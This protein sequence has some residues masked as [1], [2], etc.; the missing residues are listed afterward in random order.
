MNKK[1]EVL[2]I[3]S[4][5]MS[6]TQIK[7]FTEGKIYYGERSG[8][9]GYYLTNNS[10]NP[11]HSCGIEFFDK[12]FVLINKKNG[13]NLKCINSIKSEGVEIFIKGRTYGVRVYEKGLTC[14]NAQGNPVDLPL[15]FLN[16]HFESVRGL[17]K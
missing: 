12:Y 6:G 14:I 2:C 8:E 9:N 1:V 7:A 5:I 13:V 16:K 3:K 10:G 15:A 4:V 17:S 11:N